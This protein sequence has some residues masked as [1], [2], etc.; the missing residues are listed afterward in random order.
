M[1]MISNILRVDWK[2]CVSE[3]FCCRGARVL[4]NVI[5]IGKI[6]PN[7]FNFQSERDV[8]KRKDNY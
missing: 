6:H 3:V 4:Q 7:T 8:T 1:N 2:D 5:K